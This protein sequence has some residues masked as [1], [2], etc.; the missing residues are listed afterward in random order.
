M[1]EGPGVASPAGEGP[2]DQEVDRDR[3]AG[4]QVELAEQ[5]RLVGAGR[6]ALDLAPVVERDGELDGGVA[7]ELAVDVAVPS[8]DRQEGPVLVVPA[9]A[10]LADPAVDLGLDVD[11][12][13]GPGGLGAVVDDAEPLDVLA[14]GLGPAGGPGQAVPLGDEVGGQDPDR[15][16]PPAELGHQE[17]RGPLVM[18]ERP[19]G[20][21]L[22]EPVEP[23]ADGQAG[24]DRPEMRPALRQL[25][26]GG[27][28]VGVEAD[29]REIDVVGRS[30]GIDPGRHHLVADEPLGAGERGVGRLGPIGQVGPDDRILERAGGR[31]PPATRPGPV[32][33]PDV[34]RLGRDRDV[35]E[36]VDPL[37]LDP[38]RRQAADRDVVGVELE[39]DFLV[40]LDRV[41]PDHHRRPHPR[42]DL[43]PMPTLRR[44]LDPRRQHQTSPTPHPRPSESTRVASLRLVLDPGRASI[45]EQPPPR[46]Q[47]AGRGR[48]GDATEVDPGAYP[49]PSAMIARTGSGRSP[50]R[51]GDLGR[52]VLELQRQ[53]RRPARTVGRGD[54][55]P[56]RRGR[57]RRRRPDGPRPRP[58]GR[59]TLERSG[60]G[61]TTSASKAAPS[62]ARST[63]GA[64]RRPSAST[65]KGSGPIL[66]AA[67]ILGLSTT[68][69]WVMPEMPDLEADRAEVAALHI[70]RLGTLARRLECHGIRLGLEVIGVESFRAGRGEPFVAR[71]GDL[72][73][74]LG[75]IWAESP[76]LGILLDAFHLHAAGE[77]IEAG[78]AWGIDRVGLGPRRRPAAW[79][80]GRTFGD[81]RREPG[82]CPARTGRSTSEGSW[83]GWRAKGTKARS[84]SSRWRTAGSLAGLEP[85]GD[86]R[87]GQAVARLG[88]ATPLSRSERRVQE[89]TAQSRS[90]ETA[91][92]TFSSTR[93]GAISSR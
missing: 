66:E 32:M 25:P 91:T 74:E 27:P 68:G 37:V 82:A 29:G 31:L 17:V 89:A 51:R 52:H 9:Q 78:L 30:P 7:G 24:D 5:D 55:R 57:L 45:V 18:L 75:A 46:A 67:S 69:T 59:S 23:A 44:R 39:P 16:V 92:P 14:R 54:A 11:P 47:G 63:G 86:R 50:L 3:L 21:P 71:L 12:E 10:G 38:E 87:S 19:P 73:R 76:N 56:G 80:A 84:R 79:R 53:G 58:L 62:R 20:Q 90:A 88:L 8:V 35:P 34:D 72:D 36:A 83:R 40:G 70:R 4:G 42:A 13:D 49:H 81:H 77:P 48:E 93:A 41:G 61:W 43:A 28:D 26:F 85:A 60:R 64:T 33:E 22:A 6:L 1:L 65:S 2:A 15:P